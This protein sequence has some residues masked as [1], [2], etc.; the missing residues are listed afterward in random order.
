[1]AAD[2]DIA[3]QV[4]DLNRGLREVEALNAQILRLGSAEPRRERA[5]RPA[6]ARD[7]RHGGIVPL[8]E[9]PRDNGTSR[10]TPR[11][12]PRFSTA[13]PPP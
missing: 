7:R 11:R 3:R 4:E 9:Y 13:A 2:A 10:S 12:A 6:P 1:M 8:R 5:C